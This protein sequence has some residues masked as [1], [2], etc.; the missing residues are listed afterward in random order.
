MQ[1]R[2]CS[3]DA[4]SQCGD[5]ECTCAF[6]LHIHRPDH[7]RPASLGPAPAPAPR[8]PASSPVPVAEPVPVPA[9]T[10]VAILD[11]PAA[12]PAVSEPPGPTRRRRT[13]TARRRRKR[14]PAPVVELSPPPPFAPVTGAGT[15]NV[16]LTRPEPRVAQPS[17]TVPPP[18][19][20]YRSDQDPARRVWAGR[21]HW[22]LKAAREQRQEWQALIEAADRLLAANRWNAAS[23]QLVAEVLAG[24]LDPRP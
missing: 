10:A 2:M 4:H 6:P 8:P 9:A 3:Y 13:S 1:C 5:L 14:P 15:V 23:K 22:K 16:T 24:W 18:K 7:P 21:I 11:E 19:P 17:W 20:A 12:A